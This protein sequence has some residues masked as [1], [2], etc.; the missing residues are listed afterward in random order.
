MANVI[1]FLATLDWRATLANGGW[2]FIW[3]TFFG[4]VALALFEHRKLKEDVDAASGRQKTI[5]Q[6]K[7]ALLWALPVLSL[8]AAAASQWG[9]EGAERKIGA[10][11]SDLLR[12]KTNV[13]ELQPRNRPIMTIS[14]TAH[15]TVRGATN[16]YNWDH[17]NP[18]AL[19]AGV[20]TLQCGKLV[21]LKAEK[22]IRF[23]GGDEW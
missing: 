1:S 10:L 9:S 20:A 11:E 18:N 23:G 16:T 4:T 19:A 22:F 21:S 7:L 2:W 6:W 3:P 14:A 12:E 13:A 15:F 8:I 5:A 17:N